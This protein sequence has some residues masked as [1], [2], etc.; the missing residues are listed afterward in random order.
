[1]MADKSAARMV[2]CSAALLADLSDERTAGTTADESVACSAE[3]L[4]S[5]TAV[6]RVEK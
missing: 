5:Q 2:D 6:S 3:L 4:E 1:L